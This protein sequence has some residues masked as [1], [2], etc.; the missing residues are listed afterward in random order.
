VSETGQYYGSTENA[1]VDN[2]APNSRG[3]KRGSK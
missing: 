3:G 1:G 2:V